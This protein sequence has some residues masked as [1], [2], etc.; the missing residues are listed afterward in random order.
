MNSAWLDLL[1]AW[2]TIAGS[3][4]TMAVMVPMYATIFSLSWLASEQ[5][6]CDPPQ[7]VAPMRK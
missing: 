6:R 5:L 4:A 1:Q 7:R 2:S 3:S